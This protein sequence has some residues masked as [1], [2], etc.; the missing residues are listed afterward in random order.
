VEEPI[1]ESNTTLKSLREEKGMTQAEVAEAAGIRQPHYSKI[2]RGVHSPNIRTATKI[3][4]ALDVDVGLIW[5]G[6]G[7]PRDAG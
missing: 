6:E 1:R 7:Q 3:A 4:G 2:E 5:P